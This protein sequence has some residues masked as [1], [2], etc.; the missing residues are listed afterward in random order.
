MTSPGS[1]PYDG[2]LLVSF[3]GPEGPDEV[4]PFLENVTRGR[5]VPRARLLE[6]AE[7]YH[8]FGG[9]SPI[10]AHNRR[11]L[12]AIRTELAAHGSALPA[13]WGN[14]HWHPLL[15]DTVRRMAAYGIRRALAF[16]TS[17]FSSY[18]ACRQY[19]EDIERAVAAVGPG[20]PRIDKLRLFY[21][22]PGFID[23]VVDHTRAALASLPAGGRA[24]HLAFTAHSIPRSM[25]ETSDYEVQLLDAAA[26]VVERLGGDRAW[27]LVYQSRSGPPAVPWLG[28]DIGDHLER[29]SREGV[30]DVVVVPIGFVSDHMEV[31]YDLDTEAAARATALGLRLVR[32]ATAGT[33]P[34]FVRMIREL[35]LERTAGAPPRALGLRGPA[36]DV[37][38]P[39][40]CPAPPR[41][42]AAGPERPGE[43]REVR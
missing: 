27:R 11:L 12:E 32:A 40:C 22:H 25:A 28:P 20:A 35:V 29:L 43:P 30:T 15:E 24:A 16:V 13:Y 14:R 3:G 5:G 7:H 41:P 4:L 38:S 34:A 36:P 26:L 6:V 1:A 10:N 8:H 2:F 39:G 19:R 37:C 18:S 42:G 9:V 17:G 23:A 31:R 33:H 21:N